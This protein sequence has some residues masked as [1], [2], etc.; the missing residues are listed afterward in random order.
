MPKILPKIELSWRDEGYGSVN[1]VTAFRNYAGSFD[2]S[3][4][5]HQRF[6]KYAFK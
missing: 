4:R 1:A 6:R 5:T 3:D 2:W